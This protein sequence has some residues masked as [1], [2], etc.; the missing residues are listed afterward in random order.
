MLGSLEGS[1]LNCLIAGGG[2]ASRGAPAELADAV[3]LAWSTPPAAA[4]NMIRNS[5]STALNPH[6][7]YTPLD[8]VALASLRRMTSRTR[9]SYANLG[10]KEAVM[11]LADFASQDM[12]AGYLDA[13]KDRL[14]ADPLEA[15]R[16]ISCRSVLWACMRGMTAALAPIAPYTAEDVFQ[17]SVEIVAASMGQPS[18]EPGYDPMETPLVDGLTVMDASWSHEDFPAGWAALPSSELPLLSARA[19]LPKDG[20]FLIE[21]VHSVLRT[22]RAHVDRLRSHAR[23][24][25]VVGSEEEV[26]VHVTL[27]GDG[28]VEAAEVLA[29]FAGSSSLVA[30]GSFDV[31][32]GSDLSDS[33]KASGVRVSV[34]VQE[35]P[36]QDDSDGITFATTVALDGRKGLDYAREIAQLPLSIR[37]VQTWQQHCFVEQQDAAKSQP[38][39]DAGLDPCLEDKATEVVQIAGVHMLVEIAPADG[40]RCGRCWRYEPSVSPA[41]AGAED[42]V[43]LC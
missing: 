20:A 4:I 18:P 31:R 6:V 3:T 32:V 34:Q 41:A 26:D 1:D 11:A 35:P 30:N 29:W 14:Y 8:R 42:E 5:N 43:A 19:K 22:L 39:D 21:D 27:S 15:P 40:H 10:T 17:H 16:S 13:C 12:S 28:A 33:L 25:G 37:G 36:A 38:L 24:E 7:Q 9:R 23:V 2:D